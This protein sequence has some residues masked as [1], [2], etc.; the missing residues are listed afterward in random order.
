MHRRQFLA[1]CLLASLPAAAGGH[2]PVLL[3]RSS[4][5]TVNI[6]DLAH[7]PGVLAL[8]EK[9][10]PEAEVRLWAIDVD[11][12]VL[13][14]LRRRFPELRRVR[15]DQKAEAFSQGTRFENR[16]IHLL[17]SHPPP[18]PLL[19]N[20]RLSFQKGFYSTPTTLSFPFAT[21]IFKVRTLPR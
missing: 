6:G 16:K 2:K 15:D 19:E 4:W 10:L 8:L 5:Q 1:T 3:L 21:A 9:Y 17:H 11:R 13:E 18:H 14:M 20:Q 7:T 12:G